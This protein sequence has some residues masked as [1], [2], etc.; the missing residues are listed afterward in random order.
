MKIVYFASLRRQIGLAEEEI[1]LP[2]DIETVGDLAD[3]LK[4][5]SPAHKAALEGCPKLMAAVNQDYADALARIS[6]S[7]E[8]AFFPPVTGG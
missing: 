1:P 2:A 7:D 4:Q 8:I 6:D 3:W 5:R